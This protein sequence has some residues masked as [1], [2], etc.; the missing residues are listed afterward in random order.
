[1]PQIGLMS[2]ALDGKFEQVLTSF[3]GTIRSVSGKDSTRGNRKL[4]IVEFLNSSDLS[5]FKS[6]PSHP[7]DFGESLA[8]RLLARSTCFSGRT[9]LG[10]FVFERG[11]SSCSGRRGDAHVRLPTHRW[12]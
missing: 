4:N 11:F 5:P 7:R 3:V 10:P 12:T 6:A 2:S 9:S 8:S 1:M